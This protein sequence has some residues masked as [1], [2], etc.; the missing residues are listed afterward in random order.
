MRL[1]LKTRV[2]RQG[3][4]VSSDSASTT[5]SPT[6]T[7]SRPAATSV[8]PVAVLLSLTCTGNTSASIFQPSNGGATKA[9]GFT[10][11]CGLDCAASNIF[12]FEKYNVELCATTCAGK[13][14]GQ[15]GAMVF[16]YNG[17][18]VKSSTK[19]DRCL[20]TTSCMPR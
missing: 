3:A 20:L 8:A 17:I 2:V 1:T 10:A 14:N 16:S 12:T 7:S 13:T 5:T 9:F 11:S 15:C 19:E 6:A 18:N 4:D